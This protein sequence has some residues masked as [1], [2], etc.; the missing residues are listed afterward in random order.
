MGN[1]L[2]G[3]SESPRLRRLYVPTRN[4]V[5]S[6]L[7]HAGKQVC[8]RF[9]ASRLIREDKV[10]LLIAGNAVIKALNGGKAR[11]VIED[12]VA[13]VIALRRL[14]PPL[15]AGSLRASTPGPA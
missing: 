2:T 12:C 11:L 10:F 1:Q 7:R 15:L 14:I 4:T 6:T 8:V 5:I 13:V 3:I 9:S